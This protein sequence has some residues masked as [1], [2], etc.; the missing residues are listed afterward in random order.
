[1]W[2]GCALYLTF[3]SSI[4]STVLPFLSSVPAIPSVLHVLLS[5]LLYGIP[6]LLCIPLGALCKL[7]NWSE[8]ISVYIYIGGT[9]RE[10]PIFASILVP[11]F[12]KKGI[13]TY[14]FYS[15]T[16]HL[17]AWC[18]CISVY[19]FQQSPILCVSVYVFTATL[20]YHSKLFALILQVL[21]GKRNIKSKTDLL[22]GNFLEPKLFRDNLNVLQKTYL[23]RQQQRII[24]NTSASSSCCQRQKSTKC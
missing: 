3:L 2:G 9:E 15:F 23:R 5:A 24:S 14:T 12:L 8:I 16:I 4:L 20:N 11:F 10:D 18:V 22:I 19:V 17:N 21:C 7:K 13:V 1:M 6:S